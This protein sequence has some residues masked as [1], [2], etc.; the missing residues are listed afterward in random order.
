MILQDWWYTTS[1]GAERL[2]GKAV[3]FSISNASA[4]YC[5]VDY[6]DVRVI[7]QHALFTAQR[8]VRQYVTEYYVPAIRGEPPA[9]GP[10][11]A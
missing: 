4:K 1:L 2:L 9:D 6:R 10:P 11:T 3:V 8:M 7:A 5:Q